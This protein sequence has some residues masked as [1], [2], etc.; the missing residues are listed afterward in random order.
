MKKVFL[1]LIIVPMIGFGQNKVDRTDAKSVANTVLNAFKEKDLKQLQIVSHSSNKEIISDILKKGEDHPRY[2]SLFRGWRWDAVNNWDGYSLEIIEEDARES[3]VKF[4]ESKYEDYVVTLVWVDGKWCFEDIHSPSKMKVHIISIGMNDFQLHKSLVDLQM[5]ESDAQQFTS[6]V[7]EDFHRSPGRHDTIM[8][9]SYQFNSES[10]KEQIINA[11]NEISFKARSHDKFM[12]YCASMHS[13]GNIFLSDG[14]TLSL[15]ELYRY[16]SNI[17]T[18]DKLFCLDF[19]D[20]KEFSDLF[21]EMISANLEESYL[22]SSNSFILYPS[23]S[24]ENEDGG[25]FTQS[26]INSSKDINIFDIFNNDD[27][28]N[29]VFVSEVIENLGNKYHIN[30]EIEIHLFSEKQKYITLYEEDIKRRKRNKYWN[31]ETQL[32]LKY[33]EAREQ[34][35]ASVVARRMNRNA[36]KMESD[37]SYWYA[38]SM[39]YMGNRYFEKDNDS[40]LYYWKRSVD[41]FEKYHPNHNDAVSSINNLGS[42][43]KKTGYYVLAEEYYLKS[44]KLS[45][46]LNGD[47][48][49]DYWT[50]KNNLAELYILLEGYN[51]AEKILNSSYKFKIGKDIEDVSVVTNKEYGVISL[52]GELY[53]KQSKYFLAET[54]FKKSLLINENEN[55]ISYFKSPRYKYVEG[56]TNLIKL[57][58]IVNQHDSSIVYL[59]KLKKVYKEEEDLDNYIASLLDISDVYNILHQSDSVMRYYN[60]IEILKSS[61]DFINVVVTPTWNCVNGSCIDPGT[62]NG[63]FASLSACQNNCVTPTWDCDEQGNCSDPGTGQGTYASL[64][65]CQT[66]AKETKEVEITRSDKNRDYANVFWEQKYTLHCL[67]TDDPILPVMVGKKEIYQ[68]WY[69]SN[70]DINPYYWEGSADSLEKHLYYKFKNEAICVKWCNVRKLQRKRSKYLKFRKENLQDSALVVAKEMNNFVLKTETDSSINFSVTLRYIGNVYT[71]FKEYDSAYYYYN[72]SLLYLEK[73]NKTISY[74]YATGLTNLGAMFKKKKDF[75][76]AETYYVK[77]SEV[78]IKLKGIGFKKAYSLTQLGYMYKEQS[79][80]RQSLLYFKKSSKIYEEWYLENK[81]DK[82]GDYKDGVSRYS[83][84]LRK[85]GY[86]YENLNQSDSARYYFNISKRISEKESPSSYR[87]SLYALSNSYKK[88]NPDSTVYYIKEVINV[89]ALNKNTLSHVFAVSKLANYYKEIENNMLSEEYYKK[90]IELSKEVSF[91]SQMK[92]LKDILKFYTETSQY[93]KLSEYALKIEELESDSLKNRL[94]SRDLVMKDDKNNIKKENDFVIKKGETLCLILGVQE[95]DNFNNLPNTINDAK[96]VSE[97]LKEKYLTKIIYLENPTSIEFKSKLAFIQDNYTFEEGSQFFF[98][99][100]THGVFSRWNEQ[101]LIFKDSKSGKNQGDYENVFL[102][103]TLQKTITNTISP[104]NTLIILD[105][106]YGGAEFKKEGSCVSPNS[107]PIP[108]TNPLFSTPFPAE[109][110]SNLLTEKENIFISSSGNQTASDGEENNSP[111]TKLLLKFLNENSSPLS[112]NYYLQESLSYEKLLAENAFSAP[113][114]CSYNCLPS[115]NNR[116]LFIKK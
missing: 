52:L 57:Y 84:V 25:N 80:F 48:S 37:T 26:Y 42:L 19:Q 110:H 76:S 11:F 60:E 35:S 41:L 34:D 107:V 94:S 8:F 81:I 12:F 82:K 109:L 71:S 9:N 45:K 111:F 6:R 63:I 68:I 92:S 102:S 115:E 66:A 46:K 70:E 103:L 98:F 116:F 40:C 23:I 86:V 105:V 96:G 21:E 3:R 67:V 56:L 43:Y 18:T 29:N 85:I 15:L 2:N 13:N 72:K 99:A 5:C 36:L 77:G 61:G 64:S 4:G 88:T 47:I 89:T 65:A 50:K 75:A 90:S 44:I 49:D 1:L 74:D 27:S 39:R 106:C 28:L 97:V 69:S 108:L 10:T 114:F 101:M 78:F 54:Y 53:Y 31:K 51:K 79:K 83:Y 112:D 16:S 95:F 38:L 22:S 7:Y 20:V 73:Y 93:T 24:L 14:T 87:N 58:N 91:Q 33:R 55:E 59:M 30:K 32:F 104:T 100:A 17:F 113:M 62:G